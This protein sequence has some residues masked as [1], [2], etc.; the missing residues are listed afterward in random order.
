MKRTI[1]GTIGL[2]LLM[3]TL[4]LTACFYGK[5]AKREMESVPYREARNYFFNNGDTLREGQ[6]I[7]NRKDLD[8][9]FGLAAFM[10]KGGEPMRINF[11][12]EF[13]LPIVLPETDVETDIKAIVLTG[14]A[15]TL[16][17]SYRV[18][19]G[20]KQGFT[21]QPIKLLVVSNE[22]KNAKVEVEVVKE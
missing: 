1:L 5:N 17:L 22:F 9:Y 8:R 3:V 6:K 16:H 14:N 21:T 15:Q 12:K 20:E 2:S 19:T 13:I 11:S 4:A 7:T 18:E 10:G